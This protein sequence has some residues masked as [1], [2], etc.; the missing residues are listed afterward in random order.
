MQWEKSPPLPHQRMQGWN[1]RVPSEVILRSRTF[2]GQ[3]KVIEMFRY[4][5]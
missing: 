1:L 2:E 4:A 3:R 5:G